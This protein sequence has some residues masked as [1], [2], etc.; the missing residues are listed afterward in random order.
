AAFEEPY[1]TLLERKELHPELKRIC[2]FDILANSTDRKAGHILL[3]RH[4]RLWAVDNGLTFHAEFKLRT[5]IWDFGGEAIDEKLLDD[6]A[7]L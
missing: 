1:F 7:S 3:D 5:V 2:A 6:I 4:D